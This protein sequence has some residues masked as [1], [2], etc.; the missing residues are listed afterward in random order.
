[1]RGRIGQYI[2]YHTRVD[3]KIYAAKIVDQDGQYAIVEWYAG[4]IYAS[5]EKPRKKPEANR[6]PIHRCAQAVADRVTGY[7]GQKVGRVVI[8]I[9]DRSKL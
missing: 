1:M 4:N 6:I 3:G 5:N 7:Q 2:F 9:S 8:C